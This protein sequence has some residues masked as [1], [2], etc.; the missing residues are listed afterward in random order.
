[1]E[2]LYI[3]LKLEILTLKQIDQVIISM[4]RKFTKSVFKIMIVEK[5][6]RCETMAQEGINSAKLAT[7][8]LV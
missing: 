4:V 2:D 6:L 3:P 8:D 7:N 5:I 1:M